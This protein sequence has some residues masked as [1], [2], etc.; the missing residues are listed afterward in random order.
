[1]T[2]DKCRLECLNKVI[3]WLSFVWHVTKVIRVLIIQEAHVKPISFINWNRNLFSESFNQHVIFIYSIVWFITWYLLFLEKE[4]KPY[5][6][7]NVV[8]Y[9]FQ[10]LIILLKK[11]YQK[12]VWMSKAKTPLCFVLHH[13]FPFEKHTERNIV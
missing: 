3:R 13:V 7:S 2:I 4:F 8:I 11:F 10:N 6:L 1:M 9:I 5:Y 12:R